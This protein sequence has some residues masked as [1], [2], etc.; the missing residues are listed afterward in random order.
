LNA[1]AARLALEVDAK[2]S[3]AHA[4]IC[5]SAVERPIWLVARVHDEVHRYGKYE[6][7]R[8]AVNVRDNAGGATGTVD[9]R[10]A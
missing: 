2:V 7:D 8:A 1:S 3:P 6:A 10:T 4:T 5:C 9:R